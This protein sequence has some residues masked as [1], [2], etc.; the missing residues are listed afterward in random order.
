MP[1]MKRILVGGLGGG[2]VIF[3][4]TGVINGTILSTPLHDWVFEMGPHMNPLPLP[5]ALLL[6][7]VMSCLLGTSGVWLFARIAAQ[8]PSVTMSAIRAGLLVWVAGKAAVALDF[9][10][11][12]L[13]PT[14]LLVGQLVSG[15][16]EILFGVYVGARFYGYANSAAARG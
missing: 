10:A 11:L 12:G 6:W 15:L 16:V 9:M 3:G 4:I 1:N 2:M 5:V 8:S 13:L 14:P 7:F